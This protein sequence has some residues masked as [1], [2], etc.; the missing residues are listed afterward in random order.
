MIGAIQ[1]PSI[2]EAYLLGAS[3]QLRSEGTQKK[4]GSVIA[5]LQMPL[6]KKTS[7]LKS[8]TEDLPFLMAPRAAWLSM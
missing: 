8:G 4:T 5:E 1:N 7:S 2:G 6:A 3:D